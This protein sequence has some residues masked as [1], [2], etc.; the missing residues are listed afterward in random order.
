MEPITASPRKAFRSG[1]SQIDREASEGARRHQTSGGSKERFTF[2][3][4]FVMNDN[5]VSSKLTQERPG[6]KPTHTG[7]LA[8][9][10]QAD[11]FKS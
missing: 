4:E 10:N 5:P 7:L 11:Y 1:R 2:L 3:A 9:L 6:W 8:D